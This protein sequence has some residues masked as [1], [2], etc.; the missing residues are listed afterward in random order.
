[1]ADDRALLPLMDLNMWEMYRDMTR[2][3]DGGEIRE[4]RTLTMIAVPDAVVWNNLALVRAPIDPE[5][6]IAEARAFYAAR[7]RP[8]A[9]YAR[10]HADQALEEA[11][12]AR[13]FTMLVANPGMALRADP[14]TV[15]APA[16]LEIRAVTDAQGLADYRHV[17]A[18]AYAT[19]EQ[20]RELAR[21]LF[22]SLESVC[23]P[24]VQG[25]VGYVAGTPVAGATLYL[26]HGVAGVGE[27]GTVPAHRGRR[28]AEAVT[29]AVVREGLRRGATFANLQAAPMGA[30]V[31]TRMGFET[32]TEYRILVGR[33]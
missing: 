21:H 2:V 25:F 28:Y 1:M 4:T 33:V 32:L 30:P 7:R 11:L 29:W 27:V 23:A 14:G 15:C 9:V 22:A 3:A 8:F 12:V 31:Y 13:G 26:T 16:G 20:P 10:A 24:G 6:L 18:E 5:E 19:Y 17:T